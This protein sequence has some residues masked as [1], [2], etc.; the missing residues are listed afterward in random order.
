[1]KVVFKVPQ[2]SWR[3]ALH[4]QHAYTG[5]RKPAGDALV[6]TYHDRKKGLSTKAIYTTSQPTTI[7]TFLSI[8]CKAITSGSNLSIPFVLN[9]KS[10]SREQTQPQLIHSVS[11][12]EPHLD[13]Q[14]KDYNRELS[15]EIIHTE[16][17]LSSIVVSIFLSN[18][19]G[20]WKLT[21][22]MK[23]L[24]DNTSKVFL[25]SSKHLVSHLVIPFLKN[26]PS[27]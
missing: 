19:G 5:F 7:Q 12:I 23:K 16:Y 26:D 20:R 10:G 22:L 14:E 8:C 13:S 9:R 21:S 24:G 25:D 18:G 3:N 27:S 1:M 15:N 17:P 2:R 6:H 11:P 4:L